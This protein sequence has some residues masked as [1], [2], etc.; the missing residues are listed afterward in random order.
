MVFFDVTYLGGSVMRWSLH[1]HDRDV[2]VLLQE[3]QDLLQRVLVT[4]SVHHAQHV[5]VCLCMDDVLV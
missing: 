3:P 1:E 4:A 2:I 5:A